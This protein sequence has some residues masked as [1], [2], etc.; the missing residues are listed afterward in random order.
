MMIV[1]EAA[2]IPPKPWH[3][4]LRNWKDAYPA[5]SQESAML[6]GVMLLWFLFTAAALLFVADEPADGGNGADGDGAEGAHRHC[7]RSADAEF[8]VRHVDGAAGR[9]HRRLSDELVAGGQPSQARHDDDAPGGRG[10]RRTRS[11]QQRRRGRC[12]ACRQPHVHG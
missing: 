3:M 7:G 2:N 10:C 11:R 6:D 5:K 8:L 12:A 1:A 9:L 4:A